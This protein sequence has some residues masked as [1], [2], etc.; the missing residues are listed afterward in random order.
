MLNVVENFLK[1]YDLI[2]PDNTFLVA[3]SGGCDSLC[4]LDILNKLAQKYSYKLVALH[5]NHNW[6]GRESEKEAD[7]CKTFCEQNSIEFVSEILEK[8]VQKTEDAARIARYDFFKR[9]SKKYKNPNL[10]TGHTLTDNAETVIYRIAK[11][12]GIRGLQGILPCVSLENL[13]VYR[14]ILEL[15]REDTVNYC[16]E[17]DLSANQDSSNSDVKYKRNFIRHKISPLFNEINPK[18]QLAIN[19]LAKL[20]ISEN[21]IVEEYIDTLKKEIFEEEKIITSNFAKLSCNLQKHIIYNI[22]VNNGLDYDSKKIENALS[23]ILDNSKSKSGKTFSVT[24]DLWLF[25][26]SKYAYFLNKLKNIDRDFLVEIKGEGVYKIND[27]ADFVLEISNIVLQKYPKETEQIAY[28]EMSNIDT[29]N[30]TLRYRNDGDYIV[31]FGMSGSMKLK[32]YFNSKKIPNH[33]KDEILLLCTKNEVLWAIGVGLSDK[34]RVVNSP[35]HVLKL[36]CR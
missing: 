23:F 29:K 18:S 11:G 7:F 15:S 16:K 14:P 13:P 27:E 30:L 17:H 9:V 10:F 21:S 36:A 6:R 4:L 33:K 8:T 19:S 22:F 34:L 32:K 3:F 35:T 31:P 20:A 2:N 25:A 1:D 12:T 5:L 26:S 24:K 28:V